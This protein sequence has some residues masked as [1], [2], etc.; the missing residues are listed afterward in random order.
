MATARPVLVYMPLHNCII[1]IYIFV[2]WQPYKS[3]VPPAVYI[4]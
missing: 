2:A 4:V 3:K 1:I